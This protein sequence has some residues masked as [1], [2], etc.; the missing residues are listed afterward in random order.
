[1]GSVKAFTHAEETAAAALEGRSKMMPAAHRGAA[2]ASSRVHLSEDT[3]ELHS[4]R[5]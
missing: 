1:M 3:A 2:V 4:E 5:N